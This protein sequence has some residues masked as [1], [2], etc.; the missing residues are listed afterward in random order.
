MPLRVSPSDET[1]GLD[2]AQHG[3][4]LVPTV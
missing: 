4:M 3:E 1:I 2:M